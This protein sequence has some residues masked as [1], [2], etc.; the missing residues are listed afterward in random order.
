MG[1]LC[2]EVQQSQIPT[3]NNDDDETVQIDVTFVAFKANAEKL[4]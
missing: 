4:S 3:Q 2:L 1:S